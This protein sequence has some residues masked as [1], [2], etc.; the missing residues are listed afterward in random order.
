MS[1]SLQ[2]R[3]KTIVRDNTSNGSDKV[4]ALFS[5]FDLVQDMTV[6]NGL[7]PGL[8]PF[9]IEKVVDELCVG[10]RRVS[11]KSALNA[12]PVDPPSGV[13]SSVQYVFFM[14]GSITF[15]RA[16]DGLVYQKTDTV[17]ILHTSEYLADFI[18]IL[19]LANFSL[20]QNVDKMRNQTVVSKIIVTSIKRTGRSVPCSTD[21]YLTDLTKQ[22]RFD[23]KYVCSFFNTTASR[24]TE[25]GCAEPTFDRDY[26]RYECTCSRQGTFALL[27]LPMA[28]NNHTSYTQ[29]TTFPHVVATE[30]SATGITSTGAVTTS[31]SIPISY[32]PRC[33]NASF[34]SQ[35]P[36]GTCVPNDEGQVV[37]REENVGITVAISRSM[38][39]T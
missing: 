8:T 32:N 15:W 20:Y 24:W 4:D 11:N 9:D 18:A 39:R 36:N 3:F 16:A 14:D 17:G 31:M 1:V 25:S 37:S 12:E 23:G 10:V 21:F 7:G 34:S 2:E 6:D 28:P 22:L 13:H 5:Y 19:I 33:D 27:W 38:L 30:T 26:N 35:L 29:D